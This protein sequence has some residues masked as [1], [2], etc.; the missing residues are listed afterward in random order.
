VANGPESNTQNQTNYTNTM[1]FA[2]ILTA[3]ISMLLVSIGLA[4]DKAAST[5]YLVSMTGV[6]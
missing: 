5:T 3:L 4:D 2:Q 1:K 6:T